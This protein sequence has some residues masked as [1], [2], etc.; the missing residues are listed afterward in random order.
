MLYMSVTGE[1]EH[2]NVLEAL[3]LK[4]KLSLTQSSLYP[5]TSSVDFYL[6]SLQ[7]DKTGEKC[8]SPFA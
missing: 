2:D 6:K 1:I 3:K 5:N 7:L 4:E 8:I